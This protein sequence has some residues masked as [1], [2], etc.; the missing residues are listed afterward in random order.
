MGDDGNPFTGNEGKQKKAI[1]KTVSSA[2]NSGVSTQFNAA[3]EFSNLISRYGKDDDTG[4][5]YNMDNTFNP[6]AEFNGDMLGMLNALRSL[7]E[8]IDNVQVTVSPEN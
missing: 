7:I 8:R 4:K 3:E 1:D 6:L 2:L 5:P